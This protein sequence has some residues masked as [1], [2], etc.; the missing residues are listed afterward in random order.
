MDIYNG[1][2]K[3]SVWLHSLYTIQSL[4]TSCLYIK[5]VKSASCENQVISATKWRK[6]SRL[7]GYTE[8]KTYLVLQ[9]NYYIVYSEAPDTFFGGNIN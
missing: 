5:R 2:L 7:C 6:S 9:L 8:V 1:K 3:Q 4:Y